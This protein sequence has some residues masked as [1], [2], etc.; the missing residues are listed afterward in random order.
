MAIQNK[1]NFDPPWTFQSLSY[2]RNSSHAFHHPFFIPPH[3]LRVTKLIGKGH[4]GEVFEGRCKR[5]ANDASAKVAVKVLLSGEHDPKQQKDDIEKELKAIYGT[6]HE[7][8]V[9]IYGVC[10]KNDKACFV[11]E[12]EFQSNVLAWV[13]LDL[14]PIILQMS[15]MIFGWIRHKNEKKKRAALKQALMFG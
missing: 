9:E 2:P 4:F 12:Y 15:S 11:M 8:I 1:F 13:F 10:F 14:I 6:S 7:K 5:F 3:L